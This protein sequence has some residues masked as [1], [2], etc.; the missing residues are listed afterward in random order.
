MLS[1]KA[2]HMTW[3]KTMKTAMMDGLPLAGMKHV[4]EMSH[5][6]L[7]VGVCTCV[8]HVCVRVCAC[9]CVRVCACVFVCVC[10]CVC[11]CVRVCVLRL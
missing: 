10:A 6:E 11:V 9:V 1:N 8:V 2:L 4:V 7:Q 3:R 5:A